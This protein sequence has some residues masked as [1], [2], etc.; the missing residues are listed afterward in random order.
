MNPKMSSGLI[1]LILIY[2]SDFLSAYILFEQIPSGMITK[3]SY[4]SDFQIQPEL[5]HSLERITGLELQVSDNFLRLKAPPQTPLLYAA[6]TLEY[7]VRKAVR[8]DS[9][10][11]PTARELLLNAMRSTFVYRVRENSEAA[12]GRV[13]SLDVIELDFRDFGGIIYR[14]VPKE[15]FDVGMIFFHE[16]VHRHLNLTDPTRDQIKKDQFAKGDTVKFVNR[17]ER[18]LGLPE[19]RHYAP[20][21]IRLI[22]DDPKWGIYFGKQPDRIEIDRSFALK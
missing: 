3:V 19:R 5:I 4:R 6:I 7:A 21:K 12:L 22:R 13:N 8:T 2:F 11:S 17:I 14:D 18:E 15:A 20:V 16:L 10:Y 9:K 1:A